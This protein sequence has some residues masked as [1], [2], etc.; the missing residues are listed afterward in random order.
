MIVPGPRVLSIQQPWA[1]AIAAGRKKVE[2]RSWQNAYRGR[3]YI[4]ASGKLNREGVK[5]LVRTFRLRVPEDLTQGAV[6]AVADLVDV[7]TR[8]RAKRFGRWFQG[9][10]GFVLS[11]VQA[12]RR[13]VVTRGKLGLYRP[14]ASL[15]RCVEAQMA[16]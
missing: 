8:K 9:P 5:W 15:R 14:S 6:V 4:H 16:R 3:V 11:N 13:P 12:L 2:N 1:W 7:V 10:Y